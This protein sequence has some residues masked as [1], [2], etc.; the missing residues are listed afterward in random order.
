VKIL[1]VTARFGADVVGAAEEHAGACAAVLGQGHAVEIATTTALNA[2]RPAHFP[3]GDHVENGLR[4]HRFGVLR[5]DNAAETSSPGLL[6]FLHAEGRRFD[7]IL[8]YD[9]QAPSTV[10]GLP[11]VPERAALIPMSVGGVPDERPFGAL[12][13]MARAIGFLS[14]EERLRINDAVHVEH[15][16][17]ELLLARAEDATPGEFAKPLEDLV[18]LTT[19]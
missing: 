8:F 14:T 19:A 16:P 6:S 9:H 2:L 4:V 5:E 1:L 13:Q 17:Y 7:A 18:A 11:I 10:L 3:P 15:I 12:F